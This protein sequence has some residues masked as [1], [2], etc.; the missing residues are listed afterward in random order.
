MAT[1][2]LLA[3][4]FIVAGERGWSSMLAVTLLA[5]GAIAA[6]AFTAIER[7]VTRPMVDPALFRAQAFRI[8]VAIG[9]IFNFC[10]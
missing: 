6:V 3:A 10:L 8:S 2:L 7:A 4:G 1:L 5:A 9:L